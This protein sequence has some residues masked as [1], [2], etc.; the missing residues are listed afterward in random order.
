V[1]TAWRDFLVQDNIL[2]LTI[3]T[4]NLVPEAQKII[5]TLIIF[6]LQ[7]RNFCL[8]PKALTIFCMFSVL[9]S[10]KNLLLPNY[11]VQSSIN[12]IINITE[13]IFTAS[14][15]ER[16]RVYG[17]SGVQNPEPVKAYTEQHC[18]RIVTA[19]TSTQVFLFTL[20][21]R[22]DAEMNTAN[23]LE[24]ST[25]NSLHVSTNERLTESISEKL[26]RFICICFTKL[27]RAH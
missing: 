26:S 3:I 21:W 12:Y 8:F 24:M 10:N 22:Y 15:A 17:S 4:D 9:M 18:K 11:Y 14:I 7:L 13:N 25:A 16:L 5:F 19:S 20:S 6:L 23:S 27:L 2:T 1:V